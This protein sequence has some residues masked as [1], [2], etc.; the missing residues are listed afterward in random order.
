MAAQSVPITEKIR[1]Y[2]RDMLSDILIIYGEKGI[3]PFKRPL[4][5][6]LPSL[7]LLYVAVYSPLT[8]KLARAK[9]SI[10][11]MTAIAQYAEEYDA[12]KVQMRALQRRLPLIKDKSEWLSYLINST[13]RET[14]VTVD[15]QGAQQ[16]TEV[17]GYLVVSR[18]ITTTTSYA[19]FGKWLAA[20]EN[21]P[22]FVRIT[23]L[24]LNREPTNPGMIKVTFT[25]S[26][27]FPRPGAMGGV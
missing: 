8:D 11:S 10:T 4:T 9:R 23:E 15:S 16:E 3:T 24:N 7:L 20:M 12:A 27:I 17:G 2:F 22:I 18:E 19:L 26:T 1:A 5:I 6:A 21:S 25:I 14:G 13:S